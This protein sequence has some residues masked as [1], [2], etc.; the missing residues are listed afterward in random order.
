MDTVIETL[1]REVSRRSEMRLA[2]LFGSLARGAAKAHS[3][4][5]ILIDGAVDTLALGAELSLACGHQVDVVRTRDV[6]Y[7]LSLELMRDAVCLHERDPGA[8]ALWR[9]RSFATIDMDRPLFERMRNAR[10]RKLA[11][12]S[13]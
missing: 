13:R 1:R 11:A 10:L 8:Y 2:V 6:T 12:P 7:A 4:V 5:D 3:D 9:S